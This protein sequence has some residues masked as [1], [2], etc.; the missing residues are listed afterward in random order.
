M[1]FNG[2]RFRRICP[3]SD[4][5]NYDQSLSDGN[6]HFLQPMFIP[7]TKPTIYIR[8]LTA[9][10]IIAFLL[11]GYIGY[12]SK[13]LDK[14][15]DW[16]SQTIWRL[17]WQFFLGYLVPA[18]AAFLLVAGYFAMYGFNVLATNYMREDY[19]LV[20][21]MLVVINLFVTVLIFFRRGENSIGTAKLIL[22]LIRLIK[23]KHGDQY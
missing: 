8:S 6:G 18:V 17:L 10:F 5:H 3:S 14:R 21:L 12:V 13:R 9:S 7:I 2:N 20:L 4:T 19:T 22:Q 16:Y 11:T 15:F 1:C 23:K